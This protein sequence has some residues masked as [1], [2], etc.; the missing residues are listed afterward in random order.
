MTAP[1]SPA[2]VT[3]A[4]LLYSDLDS[5]LAV[6]RRILERVPDGRADFRPHPKS[7]ELGALA[8]HL[9]ELPRLA[10]MVLSSDELDWATSPYVPTAFTTTAAVLDSFDR[11]SAAM[12]AAVDA[13]TWEDVNKRWVMRA[14][15]QIFVE[16]RKGPLVRTFGLSH[17]A[18]HRGQLGVYLRLLDIP[19]PSVYGPTADEQ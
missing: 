14:G 3:P 19:V 9:A 8:Q 6:T 7:T 18:H 5:E 4:Q 1:F 13:M 12:R 17:I 16:G 15:D 11:E 10:V 2:S